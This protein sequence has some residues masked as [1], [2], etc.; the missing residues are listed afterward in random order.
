[1]VGREKGTDGVKDGFAANT[2]WS[3][4]VGDP[5]QYGDAHV[6]QIK[7]DPH[8]DRA[9]EVAKAVVAAWAA[10][11]TAVV[12]SMTA[13]QSGS[14]RGHGPERGMVGS[15]PAPDVLVISGDP[16]VF[17]QLAGGLRQSE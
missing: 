6:A 10:G 1:M 15:V 9:E 11:R 4:G 12:A 13:A 8:Q 2:T 3:V 14:Y 5:T 7:G 16:A 17:P